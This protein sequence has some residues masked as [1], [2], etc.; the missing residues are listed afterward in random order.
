MPNGRPKKEI[1]KVQFEKLCNIQCTEEEIA[2][3]FDM[4]EDTLDREC[5]EKYGMGFSDAYKI[6]SRKGKMSI[7]RMQFK[8]AENYPAM[9]IWLGKQYLGQTEQGKAEEPDDDMTG[10]DARL[11][12]F[13]KK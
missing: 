10:Y 5:R 4:S 9:A 7:R 1:D 2:A 12:G 8:L 6:Y 3:W 11:K 13:R